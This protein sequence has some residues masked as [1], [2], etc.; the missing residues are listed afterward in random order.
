ML[1]LMCYYVLVFYISQAFVYW[2]QLYIYNYRAII[3]YSINLFYKLPL[4]VFSE[5]L[6]ESPATNIITHLLIMSF[7]FSHANWS[8]LCT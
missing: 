5:Q 2:N 7:C 1:V 8:V 3:L 6:G 4:L